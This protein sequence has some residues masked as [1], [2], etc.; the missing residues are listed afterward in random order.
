MVDVASPAYAGKVLA[1]ALRQMPA[2][3]I[4]A[5]KVLRASGEVP[6]SPAAAVVDGVWDSV[7]PKTYWRHPLSDRGT[8]MLDLGETR[9][10]VGVRIWNLN[11]TSGAQRGWKEAEIFVTDTPPA[12]VAAATGLVPMAAGA[13]STPDYGTLI[14]VPFVRG[15]YVELQA[16]S[17]WTTESHSGL[18]EVQVL[19][20]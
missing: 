20:F 3:P 5:V 13:A 18:S 6:E 8:I 7:D 2:E 12:P 16:K 1:I 14:E 19:G 17:L 11:E 10:V 9:T 4:K 15:R